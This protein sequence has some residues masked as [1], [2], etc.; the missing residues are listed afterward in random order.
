MPGGA[1]V[2]D[3]DDGQLTLTGPSVRVAEIEY[4]LE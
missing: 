1:V 3:I 4:H 2:V